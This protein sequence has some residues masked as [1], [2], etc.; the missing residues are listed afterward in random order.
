M[1]SSVADIPQK[2]T[3]ERGECYRAVIREGREQGDGCD[4]TL[5][6][7]QT[8]AWRLGTSLQHRHGDT[9]SIIS[10][11][12]RLHITSGSLSW[13]WMEGRPSCCEVTARTTVEGGCGGAP[14]PLW[15]RCKV[16]TGSVPEKQSGRNGAF[17]V[18]WEV[19]L[20]AFLHI[21]TQ[22]DC[23]VSNGSGLLILKLRS[24]LIT[25]TGMSE[26]FPSCGSFITAT[27]EVGLKHRI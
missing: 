11:P 26:I 22:K 13:G 2:R 10:L 16:T 6:V 23:L 21:C 18:I 4:S 8:L 7:T 14:V 12:L 20:G 19:V 5:V 25:I 9:D 27:K 1:F 24:I 3:R 15:R 17:E